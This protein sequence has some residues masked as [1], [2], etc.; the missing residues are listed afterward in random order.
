MS[1]RHPS[2]AAKE[3]GSYEPGVQESEALGLRNNKG[4]VLWLVSKDVRPSESAWVV[5]VGRVSRPN[6]TDMGWAGGGGVGPVEE[7]RR[8]S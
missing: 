3:A 4:V 1:F 8:S 5:P 2:G 7:F 6:H